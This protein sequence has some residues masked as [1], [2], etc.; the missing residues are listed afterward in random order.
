MLYGGWKYK[1]KRCTR[2]PGRRE[3][4]PGSGDMGLGRTGGASGEERKGGEP[5]K[6]ERVDRTQNL[7]RE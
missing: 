1:D 4:V 6:A 5:S 2:A 3:A 7:F